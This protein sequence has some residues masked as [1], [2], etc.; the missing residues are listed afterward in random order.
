MSIQSG[1][2]FIEYL[3]VM[4]FLAVTVWFTIMGSP[5]DSDESDASNPTVISALND[6]QHEFARDIYKP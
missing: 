5:V 3:L 6:Q 1:N 4:G 2:V